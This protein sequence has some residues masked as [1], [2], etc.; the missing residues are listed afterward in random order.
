MI[1]R[2]R[3]ISIFFALAVLSG[4]ASTNVTQQTPSGEPAACPPQSNLGLRLHRRPGQ[5]PRRCLY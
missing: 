5:A 2:N 1:I 3:A 4:C